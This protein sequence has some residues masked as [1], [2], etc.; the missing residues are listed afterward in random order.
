MSRAGRMAWG[1]AAA[2]AAMLACAA[3]CAQDGA[4]ILAP[5]VAF[6]QHLGAKLPLDL[7]LRD[8]QG[9]A[10]RLGDFFAAGRPVVLVPGYY[11]CTN[12]CSTLMQ[13]VL[14]SLADTGLPRGAYAVVGFSI[15]PSDTPAD[16]R[17]R[18]EADRAY[19]EAYVARGGQSAPADV[20]LLV[21]AADGAARAVGFNYRRL[22]AD[23]PGGTAQY[24]HAAGFVVATPE[25]RVARYLMGVRF[26][27]RDLRLALVEAASGGIGTVADRLTLLCAH[28]DPATGHYSGAVLGGLRAVG[29]ALAVGL[30]AWIVRHRHGR[31]GSMA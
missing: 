18:Q 9:R 24:A 23:G 30:G 7:P 22:P 21:G 28:V 20:H 19:A 29:I 11:H 25:G 26:T 13:G 12:L 2:A 27:A 4:A 5:S 6:D 10:V 17:A 31:H 1:R 8:A 14:E 3:A 16:A 15:D